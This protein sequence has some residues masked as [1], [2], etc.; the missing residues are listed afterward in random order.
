L[1]AA[2]ADLRADSGECDFLA[3]FFQRAL[4]RFGVHVHRVDECSVDVEDYRLNHVIIVTVL[5]V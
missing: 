1:I 2:F 5:C 3:E 4:P